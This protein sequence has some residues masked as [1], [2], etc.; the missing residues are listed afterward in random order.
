MNSNNK[1]F[2][3][4]I[5]IAIVTLV[6]LIVWEY[7]QV[8]S[9]ARSQVDTTVVKL[10]RDTLFTPNVENHIQNKQLTSSGID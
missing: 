1:L 8:A 9:G 6:A 4:L 7:Y 3:Y 10:S 2:L 5:I